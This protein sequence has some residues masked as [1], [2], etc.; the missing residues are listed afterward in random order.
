MLTGD[1]RLYCHD[2]RAF[3]CTPLCAVTVEA[4][5]PRTRINRAAGETSHRSSASLISRAF[6]IIYH[7]FAPCGLQ[8]YL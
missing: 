3:L 6:K 2:T 5:T 4:M 7:L 1:L 8:S